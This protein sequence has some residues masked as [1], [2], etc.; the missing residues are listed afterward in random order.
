VLA[1]YVVTSGVPPFGYAFWQTFGGGCV[2][3]IINLARKRPPPGTF[4]HMLF[5][6]AV[7]WT[8]SGIPTANMYL[9][10][11]KIPVGLMAIA[12]TTV[13]LITYGL[14]LGVRIER[15]DVL[16]AAGISAGFIGAM[17]IL[18]PRGSLPDPAILPFVALAF[19]T[20]FSY[21]I[22]GVY[23]S[24]RRPADVDS[25]HVACGTLLAASM[26][27]LPVSLATGTFYPIWEKLDFVN[28]LIL[29]HIMTTAF[30]FFLYFT[31]LRLAGAVY[32]SQVT[33]IITGTAVTLGI[34]FFAETHSTWIWGALVVIVAGVALVNLR[35]RAVRR[36]PATP[37][38]G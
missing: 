25:L 28:G 16:R 29:A 6:V 21:S 3:L 2:L 8:G 11:S 19:L 22:S 38:K 30:S 31:L 33:Y 5:Y 27:M 23:A 37:P 20:P 13:P 26:L 17:M 24:V 15:F 1:K 32:F 7:G 35:Q 9:V 4:R 14:S 12:L 34:L 36:G 10:L 18:L